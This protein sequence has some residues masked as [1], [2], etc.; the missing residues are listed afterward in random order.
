MNVEC[1]VWNSTWIGLNL[2][3]RLL[4]RHSQKQGINRIKTQGTEAMFWVLDRIWNQPSL[5][6][7]NL[8]IQKV[9]MLAWRSNQIWWQRLWKSEI[10]Y[11]LNLYQLTKEMTL[12]PSKVTLTHTNP[13]L[14]FNLL[15]RG[16]TKLF[17]EC[18][19]RSN[20]QEKWPFNNRPDQSLQMRRNSK[21]LGN[22]GFT[23]SIKTIKLTSLWFTMGLTQWVYTN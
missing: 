9:L 17:Q 16:K 13:D 18:P 7:H 20:P 14:E 11:N 1:K 5:G 2:K 22:L 8:T 10:L 19:R 15:F 12:T 21:K 4:T 23:I 3:V 6:A